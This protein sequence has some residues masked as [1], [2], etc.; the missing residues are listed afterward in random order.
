[1]C[2]RSADRTYPL[3]YPAKLIGYILVHHFDPSRA[4]THFLKT[5]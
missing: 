4:F 3:P 2:E 5:I 1:M